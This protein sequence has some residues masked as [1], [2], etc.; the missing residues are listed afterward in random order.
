MIT[1]SC[2]RVRHR[3]LQSRTNTGSS[4]QARAITG[5]SY[6]A[7]A[8]AGSS[9]QARA[10]TGSCAREQSR[11]GKV[12]SPGRT[13]SAAIVQGER[14]QRNP[15]GDHRQLRSST[16]PATAIQGE[17][18]QLRCRANTGSCAR[19]QSRPDKVQSP[20]QTLAAESRMSRDS[21]I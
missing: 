14:R 20:G 15:A 13:S 17:H 12:R 16:S 1:G 4:Y 18:W 3:Q 5:S 19:E 2:A 7:R 8:I 21:D 10:I 6:Q 9:Y 11:P